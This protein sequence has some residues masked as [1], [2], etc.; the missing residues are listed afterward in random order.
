MVT[1]HEWIRSESIRNDTDTFGFQNA[2]GT[3]ELHQ[4]SIATLGTI[5]QRWMIDMTVSMTVN[6]PLGGG[7]SPLW[8][9][10]ME[11]TLVC[12]LLNP[13][14]NAWPAAVFGDQSYATLTGVLQISEI[15]ESLDGTLQTVM[16]ETQETLNS[17]AIRKSRD[18]LQAPQAVY[19]VQVRD[20]YG[21]IAAAASTTCTRYSYARTLFKVP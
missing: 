21:T 11:F 20:L 12:G 15:K 14:T 4:D 9:T 2:Q 17:E 13:F 3:I 18:P 19:G 8:W 10:G 1:T 6:I 16:W 5:I 7:V